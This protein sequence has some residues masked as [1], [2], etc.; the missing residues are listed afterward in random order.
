M[1]GL[2]VGA[3]LKTDPTLA[4]PLVEGRPEIGAQV[5]WGVERELAATVSDIM[6]RRTQLYYRDTNQGLDAID[7]CV[8]LMR[9][10]LGWTKK[11]ADQS[12]NDY[13]KEVERSRSWRGE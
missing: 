13:Q 2:D 7:A 1:R 10:R 4:E 6:I 12:A 11:Q 5:V 8:A 3:L 9:P